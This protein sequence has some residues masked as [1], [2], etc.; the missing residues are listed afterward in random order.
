MLIKPIG[1]PDQ[2][3][4]QARPAMPRAL[5]D[6]QRRLDPSL[7]QLLGDK[8][9]LLK[10][11]QRVGVAMDDQRRRIIGRD[12]GDRRNLAKL[13]VVSLRLHFPVPMRYSQDIDLVR[14]TSGRWGRFWRAFG[15]VLEPWLGHAAFDRSLVAPKLRFK[16]PVE[17]NATPSEIRMKLEINT[18]EIDAYDPP[19][20]VELGVDNTCPSR[21]M[22][23][24]ETWN[25]C[26]N[27]L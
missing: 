21:S 27:T 2:I 18:R 10:R 5:L 1:E 12:E 23:S 17:D 24:R 6:H 15:E 25:A 8:L 11:N 13:L 7:F 3:F 22:S 16:M 26:S 14:T 9:G 19:K 4:V 20:E